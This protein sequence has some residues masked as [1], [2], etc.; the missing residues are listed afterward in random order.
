M[1]RWITCFLL[2]SSLASLARGAEVLVFRKD[3]RYRGTALRVASLEQGKDGRLLIR[4]V[5][6]QF[7][8]AAPDEVDWELSRRATEQLAEAERVAAEHKREADEKAA[9]SQRS[10]PALTVLEASRLYGVA[11]PA[12]TVAGGDLS[13]ETSGGETSAS[14]PLATPAAATAAKPRAV[15]RAERRLAAAQEERKTLVQRLDTL[16]ADNNPDPVSAAI[17]RSEIARR[18]GQLAALDRR[19]ATLEQELQAAQAAAE[20]AAGENTGQTNR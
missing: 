16:R 7:L 12:V 10:R 20:A 3:G 2:L 17:R 15:D 14:P 1:S 5:D 18:E 19:I 8:S 4:G 9:A 6:G 11:N 13:G